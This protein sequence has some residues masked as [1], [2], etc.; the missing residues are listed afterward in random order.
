MTKKQFDQTDGR[1]KS[2]SKKD[3]KKWCRGVEGREHKPHWVEHYYIVGLDNHKLNWLVKECANC[4]KHLG[5]PIYEFCWGPR[6][7]RNE[8]WIAANK[9]FMKQTD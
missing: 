3:T 9:E 6:K 4:R 8:K 5:Y 2:S 7:I 1:V